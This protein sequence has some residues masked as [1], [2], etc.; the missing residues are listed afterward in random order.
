MGR[1]D[2]DYNDDY[3][4]SCSPLG[5]GLDYEEDLR[6]HEEWMNGIYHDDDEEDEDDYYKSC[7]P[8]GGG[9]DYV[10]DYEKHQKMMER[11]YAIRVEEEDEED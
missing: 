5:G 1:H 10:R 6:K 9:L 3:Y 7:S 8:L 2:Y 11:F 4:K